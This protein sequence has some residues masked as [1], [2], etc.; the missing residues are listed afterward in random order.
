M[1]TQSLYILVSDS[2]NSLV[3][4]QGY[5]YPQNYKIPI[6]SPCQHHCHY[7]FLSNPPNFVAF[8]EPFV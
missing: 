8:V 7:L 3:A 5:R 6:Q 2:C 1:I 4:C